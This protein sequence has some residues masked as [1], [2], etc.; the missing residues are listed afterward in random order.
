[1]TYVLNVIGNIVA[2][3]APPARRRFIMRQISLT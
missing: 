1:M 2:Y 3:A